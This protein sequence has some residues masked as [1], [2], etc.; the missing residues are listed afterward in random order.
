MRTRLLIVLTAAL[1]FGV[2]GQGI[3]GASPTPVYSVSCVVGGNTTADWQHARVAQVEFEWS[4]P[5]EVFETSPVPVT[6]K[7]PHGSAFSTTLL[8]KSG[9]A[10]ASVTATF[11]LTDGTVANPVQV[12]CSN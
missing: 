7:P 8:S 12:P 10:P 5:G 11:T 6:S 2:L 3:A 1:L 9:A 4:A